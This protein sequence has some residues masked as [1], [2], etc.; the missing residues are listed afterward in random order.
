MNRLPDFNHIC[1][2]ITLGHGEELISKVTTGLKLSNLS[3]K[4]LVRRISHEPIGGF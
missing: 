4:V 3:Q 2:D 1:M